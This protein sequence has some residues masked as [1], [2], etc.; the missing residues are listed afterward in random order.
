MNS[1]DGVQVQV[2]KLKAQGLTLV[3]DPATPG[4]A[5]LIGRFTNVGTETEFL[6][7]VTIGLQTVRIAALLA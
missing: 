5:T 4:A 7:G 1:G 6:R 3:L 2:G